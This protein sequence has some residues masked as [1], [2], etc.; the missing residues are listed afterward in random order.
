MGLAGRVGGHGRPGGAVM[1]GRI[2]Q[3]GSG[4]LWGGSGMGW[5]WLFQ[6]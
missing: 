2:G 4:V 5:V 1:A 6:L 3:G